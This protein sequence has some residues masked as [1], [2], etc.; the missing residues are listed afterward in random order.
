VLVHH[1]GPA[2]DGW[3]Q[4][5]ADAVRGLG[6]EPV[7]APVVRADGIAHEPARLAS[8]LARLARA[9]RPPRPSRSA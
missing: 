7:A 8:V 1:D 4:I 3:L 6:V 9:P 2:D 5:D